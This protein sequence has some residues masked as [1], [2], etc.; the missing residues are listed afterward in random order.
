MVDAQ[1]RVTFWPNLVGP[2]QGQAN[3]DEG[4]ITRGMRSGTPT[5]KFDNRRV[6][7]KLPNRRI[8]FRGLKTLSGPFALLVFGGHDYNNGLPEFDASFVGATYLFSSSGSAR[9]QLMGQYHYDENGFDAFGALFV[10]G[11][12][13][14]RSDSVGV[15]KNTDVLGGMH[16][17][18][19]YDTT[20]S[21]TPNSLAT[22]FVDGVA[23]PTTTHPNASGASTGGVLTLGGSDRPDQMLAGA[24]SEVVLLS[25]PTPPEIN[26]IR[27]A[28][29][30]KYN[31][32]P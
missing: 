13:Q 21:G 15:Y 5:I 8:E 10:N 17:F 28:M 19:V 16:L 11:T 27:Q 7:T 23:Q 25:D 31:I 32:A 4:E 9:L 6:G 22:L 20:I 12:K 1:E 26:C 18:E 24:I 3:G 14:D 29:R 30:K 2:Q